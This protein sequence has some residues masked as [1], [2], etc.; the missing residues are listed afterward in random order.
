[1]HTMRPSAGY[2]LGLYDKSPDLPLTAQFLP[3]YSASFV[4]SSH[5]A[6]KIDGHVQFH[7]LAEEI[8]SVFLHR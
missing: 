3:R 4:S 7:R 8:G 6:I 2:R 1:M 5:D